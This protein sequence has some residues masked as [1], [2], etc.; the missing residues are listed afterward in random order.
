MSKTVVA[1][2]SNHDSAVDAARRIKDKGLRTDDISIVT[3]DVQA[4]SSTTDRTETRTGGVSATMGTTN[5]KGNDNISDGV[6]AGSV[7]G[8]LTGLVIGAGTLMIP[9]FGIIAAAGPIAG[10]LSG[11][12]TGGV[13]GGL[14]D[15][16]I[17]EAKS[18]Q[19]ES[20]VKQGKTIFTM[21]TDEGK[22]DS[23]TSVLK[24]AG[25]TNVDTY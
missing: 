2:F 13:V 16:G 15:L 9:G 22:I 14:V 7:L 17:P 10:L 11:A 19:Y 23:V 25:A 4:T 6:V 21:K 8:G 5:Y 3:K 18:K 20:D 1:T 12:V 24:N